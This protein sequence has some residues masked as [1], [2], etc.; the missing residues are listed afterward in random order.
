MESKGSNTTEK[1]NSNSFYLVLSIMV[2]SMLFCG[3]AAFNENPVIQNPFDVIQNPFNNIEGEPSNDSSSS[4]NNACLGTGDES[5]IRSKMEQMDRDVLELNKI[6]ERK[7]YVR[8]I[9]WSSGT[10]V[11]GDEI[12]DYINSPCND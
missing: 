5:F 4:T 7:Y 1:T 8:Y 3:I 6:G 12:L 10:A 11:S 9:S 2:F